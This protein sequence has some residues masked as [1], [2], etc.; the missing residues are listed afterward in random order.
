M[1]RLLLATKFAAEKHSPQRRKNKDATPYIN[2]A[3]EVAE[4]LA[5]VGG[6]KDEDILIAA[7]LH[8]TIEDTDTSFKEIVAL[9]GERVARI[10]GECTD[11]KNLIQVERKRLQIVNA[12]NKS[13]E[14]KC[15]K[16]AD[17]SCNLTS[18]LEDPPIGWDTYRQ[19]EYFEWADQVI[20]GLL[21][22]NEQLDA[23]AKE[24]LA[25]GKVK[26]QVSQQTGDVE[27]ID[28]EM[29]SNLE[30]NELR[31]APLAQF[32]V[33]G[34]DQYDCKDYF[35]GDFPVRQ[36]AEQIARGKAADANGIPTS[37]SDLFFVFDD[38]GV[39][40]ERVSY[41]DTQRETTPGGDSGRWW[42]IRTDRI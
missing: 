23:R 1:N 5:R 12:S 11:D 38:Q 14:A 32:R 3:I 36:E 2:H 10:V 13:P 41:L 35:V 37:F 19:Q 39:C 30:R 9:F 8:D 7:L 20:K 24:I 16:I 31:R 25:Y 28:T 22:V 4:H 26:L 33:I 18:I 15:V 6:I 21:G 29:N 27:R 34:Y 17:K 40:L 42:R